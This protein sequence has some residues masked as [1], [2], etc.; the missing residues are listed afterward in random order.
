MK[1]LT[2]VVVALAV[3]SA[4]LDAKTPVRVTEIR[5]EHSPLVTFRVI[6]RA[7]SIN[8]LKGKEGINAL[9]A[10]MIAQGGTKDLTYQQ[11]VS[12][13]YP[14]AAGITVNPDKEITAF[15]GN[16][17]R[18]HLKEFYRIFSGLLLNPRFDPDDFTRNK[19]LLLNGLEKSLRGAGS[20]LS[21][22]FAWQA[23]EMIRCVEVTAGERRKLCVTRGNQHVATVLRALGI[24]HLDPPPPP[25]ARPCLM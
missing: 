24:T 23:L 5:S 9:T 2:L 21:T 4:T 7:G 17:H 8:D 19:D 22:P 14:W 1:T 15:V 12:A 16:V 25:E 13:L 11:V 6:L 3:C 20:G 18:D 10:L